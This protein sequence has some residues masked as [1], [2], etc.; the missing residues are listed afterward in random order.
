MKLVVD[1]RRAS[2]S[3]REFSEFQLGPKTGGRGRT[4]RWRTEQG[5]QWH[6]E[7]QRQT[8]AAYKSASFETAIRGV[9]IAD[10]W[11]IDLHGRIDQI[12]IEGRTRRLREIK[13]V[14][15]ELPADRWELAR[16]HP[17]YFNQLAAYLHLARLQPEWRDGDI[18][19]ELV[20]VSIAEGM[21]QLVPFAPEDEDFF[22]RQ[23]Q[24]V[25]QFLD[26]RWAA[27]R[28][29]RGLNYKPPFIEPRP[30]QETICEA[31]AE[32]ACR[33]SII[34]F[35]APTGYGKTGTVLDFA[36]SRMRDGLYSRVLYL[37]GKSTGQLPVMNQIATMFDSGGGVYFYQMRNKPEHAISSPLHTCEPGMGCRND[38]EERWRQ[39]GCSPLALFEN[40]TAS[41]ETVRATGRATGLCPYEISKSLLPYADVW[42][43]DYNYVFSPGSHGVFS[44]QPGFDPA[45][46]LLIIDEAHNLPSRV[47]ANFSYQYSARDADDVLS[48]LRFSGA[49]TTLILAFE[50]FYR[51]LQSLERVDVLPMGLEYELDD[52][53]SSAAEHLGNCRLEPGLLPGDA[54]DR[55]WQLFD[56]KAFLS[57]PSGGFAEGDGFQ[58][59]LWCPRNGTVSFTCLDASSEIAAAIAPF[60]LTVPMSA[61]LSPIDFFVKSCGLQGRDY[62][63][64]AAE[65]PWREGAFKVAV[66]T[67]VDTRYRTREQHYRT[68][69]GTIALL[70]QPAARP[71]AV[72]FPSYRYAETICEY[73]RLE[74]PQLY[75]AVQPRG[76]DLEEYTQFIETALRDVDT[77]FLIL[78]SGF[79]EGID[80]LGGRVKRTV[81]VGP[82]LP[83]VN[84]VQRA[85]M[86]ERDHLPREEAFRQVYQVPAMVKINQALGRLVRAPGQ[87]VAALLHCRRFRESSYQ[88]LLAP[89]YRQFDVIS[90]RRDLER[91]AAS[92]G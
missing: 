1:E 47:A 49:P 17:G 22:A 24:R 52:A 4:G 75:I 2:M 58:K 18:I 43:G 6:R 69:A 63:H 59:L 28:R 71:L 13:T 20:F 87:S 77:I 33:S 68:T 9:C 80:T 84:A 67:R 50:R 42:I 48:A 91:W 60:G 3:V 90:N 56:L 89:E 15:A 7:M 46:T 40:G 12:V 54:F 11:T 30:G 5:N 81:I 10:D 36:F 79:S 62:E 23:M 83:E 82:A 31:F 32:S 25:T 55:L 66:D 35:E 86:D 16:E 65:A 85:L 41:L 38:T 39:S 70:S 21:V 73:V 51:L 88:Q 78:G 14:N 64:L 34:L 72:Y 19:G 76:L 74:H 27:R 92:L 53:I 57:R 37:T 26:I 45:T 8:E 44:D 61:T 29:L